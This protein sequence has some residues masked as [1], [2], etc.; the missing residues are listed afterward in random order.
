MHN[1]IV[2]LIE[3]SFPLSVCI[4]VNRNIM[5]KE[6]TGITADPKLDKTVE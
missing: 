1:V 6:A 4:V 3:S 2:Q 5:Q